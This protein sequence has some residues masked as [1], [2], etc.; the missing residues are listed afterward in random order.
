MTRVN[1]KEMLGTDRTCSVDGGPGRQSEE[2]G[3]S[4]STIRSSFRLKNLDCISNNTSRPPS[5]L[6]SKDAIRMGGLINVSMTCGNISQPPV[7][8]NILIMAAQTKGR[9]RAELGPRQKKNGTD[10]AH[11]T[12]ETL[13]PPS[14]VCWVAMDTF[15]QMIYV[16][17]RNSSHL[18]KVVLTILISFLDAELSTHLF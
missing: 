3:N 10:K 14:T 13:M 4:E 11:H 7:K 1:K 8:R 18:S 6:I 15:L 12:G 16:T 9:R 2:K 5:S 17:Q